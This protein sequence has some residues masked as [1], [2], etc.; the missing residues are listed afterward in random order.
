MDSAGARRAR[1]GRADRRA[2]RRPEEIAEERASH[3]LADDVPAAAVAEIE[4]H[5]ERFPGAKIVRHLR[6]VYP[7]GELAAHV[8]GYVGPAEEDRDGEPAGRD[9]VERQYDRRLRGRNGASVQLSDHAGHALT[10]YCETEPRAGADLRLTILPKLQQTAEKLLDDAL[11]RRA[12]Q[13]GEDEPGGGAVAVM[14][15]RDGALLAAASAPR[16]DPNIFISRGDAARIDTLLHAPDR[17]L[18]D[19]VVQMAL[20]PGSTFKMLTAIALLESAGVDPRETFH[21]Q[22]YLHMPT[23][24]RCAIFVHQGVG[25][26][27]VTL[28]DALAQSCNVYFFDCAGRMGPEPLADWAGR[29][30]F[31]RPTGIDLPGEASGIV[32][33]P[34]S[35]RRLTGRDWRTADTQMTAIGQGGLTATPLQV[36]RLTAAVATGKLIAPRVS[37]DA[38]SVEPIKG[39]RPATLAAIR[40]GMEQAVAD[41]KGTAYGVLTIESLAV[42]AKTGTASV[43]EGRR[44]HA[45]LAGYVPAAEPRFAFVVVLEHAGDAAAA[46]G[47]VAKRLLLRMRELGLL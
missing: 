30:G 5:R 38:G 44:D 24:M 10:T 2:A 41:P 15:L 17:P 11:K 19:R 21:C 29:L 45:W 25:H 43:G 3:I 18:F 9:G 33:T 31:G 1:A 28:T 46:A 7:C 35:L 47:P 20:P 8:L 40:R 37:A 13:P 23:E 34:Q 6:R 16:F 12:M 14:D 22:G 36:L 27:D 39:L 42:A 26:G 4:G 32:P